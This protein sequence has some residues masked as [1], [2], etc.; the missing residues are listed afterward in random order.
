MWYVNSLLQTFSL[1]HLNDIQIVHH[2]IANDALV[3]RAR[4]DIWSMAVKDDYDCLLM[5]DA[6]M[7]WDPNWAIELI[8]RKEDV[9][10]GTAR[11]KTDEMEQYVTSIEDFKLKENGLLKAMALGCGFVKF[12]R[13]AIKA[14]WETSAEYFNENKHC[15]MVFDIGIVDGNLFGED[16]MVFKKL[17]DLGFDIWLDPKMTLAHNGAKKFRGNFQLF[18]N[19]YNEHIARQ[20]MVPKEN[21]YEQPTIEPKSTLS[22]VKGDP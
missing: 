10:G 13:D 4:N 19:R 12:S 18:V 6:D 9:V 15:R 16:T 20:Q 22:L 7:E 14:V 8:L 11:K 1:A 2:F 5:I 21:E 17:S 3:Q